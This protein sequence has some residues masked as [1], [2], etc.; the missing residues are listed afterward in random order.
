MD[1]LKICLECKAINECHDGVECIRCGYCLNI[2]HCH[3]K[4]GECIPT[5]K[6]CEEHYLQCMD[7]CHSECACQERP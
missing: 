7:G 2:E 4:T 5:L 1:N 3:N 6:D